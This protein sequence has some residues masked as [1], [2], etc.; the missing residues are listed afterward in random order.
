MVYKFFDKKTSGGAIK[1]ENMS[2][3]KLT[4]ELHKP[5][6]RKFNT[7]KVHSSF[8]DNSWSSEIFSKYA[9]AITLKDKKGITITNAQ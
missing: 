8:I 5:I 3:K 7:R 2:N 6:F 1:N 4:E 9:W